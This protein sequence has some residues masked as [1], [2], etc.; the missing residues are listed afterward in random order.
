MQLSIKKNKPA[1]VFAL[2]KTLMNLA[3]T[4]KGEK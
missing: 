4:Q 2:V 1:D 3:N